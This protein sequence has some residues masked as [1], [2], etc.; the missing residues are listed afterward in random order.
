M[1]GAVCGDI[2]GS[3]YEY[4]SIKTTAFP[5]FGEGC[6]FTDDSVL[7]I[8]V[9]EALMDGLDMV[10]CFRA[11]VR[12]YPDAG[13]GGSFKRWAEDPD[14]GPYNSYGNGAAMRVSAAGW[15]AESE[16]E[17]LDLAERTAAPTHTTRK[18]SRGPRRRPWRSGWP[19]KVQ[20][21]NAWPEP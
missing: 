13:Y 12:R 17:A 11:Y 6:E 4:R 15:V 10:A 8:A 20:T 21:A 5:L 7:T 3:I 2:V 1:L 16:A 19:V 9:A 18:A 14:A